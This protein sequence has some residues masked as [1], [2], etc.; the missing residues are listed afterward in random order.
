MPFQSGMSEMI[1]DFSCRRAIERRPNAAVS[2]YIVASYLANHAQRWILSAPMRDALRSFLLEN[3]SEIDHA[4]AT[5]I[6]A[7]RLPNDTSFNVRGHHYPE[8]AIRAAQRLLAEGGAEGLAMG[9]A[10]GERA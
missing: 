3:W 8:A 1:H 6:D 4:Y 7:D 2:W 10:A 5:L 9:R